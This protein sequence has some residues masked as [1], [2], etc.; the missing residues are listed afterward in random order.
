MIV[1][2]LKRRIWYS[3][4][5]TDSYYNIWD[6]KFVG[7]KITGREVLKANYKKKRGRH[8][9]LAIMLV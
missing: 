9:Q 1:G 8:V 3:V 2:W 6:P 7:K 5:D 4:S